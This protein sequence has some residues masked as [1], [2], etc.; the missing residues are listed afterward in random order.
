MATVTERHAGG[1]PAKSPGYWGKK[2]LAFSLPRGLSYLDM[3][4]RC[5]VSHSTFGEWMAGRA[6]VPAYAVEILADL[7][8]VPTDELRTTP[9]AKRRK[10]PAR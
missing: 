7:F 2:V 6:T 3:A 8:G 1:R 9:P 10:R 4:T 5:D